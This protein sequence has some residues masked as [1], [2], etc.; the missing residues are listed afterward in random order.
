MVI[1]SLA[2]VALLSNCVARVALELIL[3]SL[4]TSFMLASY[5]FGME[6]GIFQET[7]HCANQTAIATSQIDDIMN[8]INNTQAVSCKNVDYTIFGFSMAF[9]NILTSLLLLVYSIK[10]YAK[11]KNR[12]F[13]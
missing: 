1:F 6:Q 13:N 10:I 8:I 4:A 5:H 3:I 12:Y 9:W 7:A 2:I 11:K